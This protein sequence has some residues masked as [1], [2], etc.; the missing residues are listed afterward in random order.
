MLWKEVPDAIAQMELKNLTTEQ[1]TVIRH[2]VAEA[3]A[4]FDERAHCALDELAK[5]LWRAC[6]N[7]AFGLTN[8]VREE[9][10]SRRD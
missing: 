10:L 2:L 9:R 8:R 4:G 7:A 1:L 5:D 3:E 6:A